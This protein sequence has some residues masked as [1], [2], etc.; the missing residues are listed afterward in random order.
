MSRSSVFL[1]QIEAFLARSGMSATAFG[2]SATN[3]R[4]FVH[5]VR[6]GRRPNVDMC[7]KV[8]QFIAEYDRMQL[9]EGE[10]R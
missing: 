4:N 7:E 8:Q 1:S 5:D 10:Q 2:V 3:D 9:F 6:R